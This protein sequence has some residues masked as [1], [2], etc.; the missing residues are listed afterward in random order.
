MCIESNIFILILDFRFSIIRENFNV[1]KNVEQFENF[2][3]R[4][5]F[6]QPNIL[7]LMFLA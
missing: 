2:N 4:F 5:D 6:T 3:N 1:R 7:S